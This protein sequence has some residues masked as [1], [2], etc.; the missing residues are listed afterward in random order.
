MS[1]P[2]VAVTRNPR[3]SYAARA[4]FHP[5]ELYPEY[6]ASLGHDVDTS[7]EVYPLVRE[8]LRQ[9]G[10]DAARY[11]SPDWNP[12]GEMIRPGESVVIKPNAVWDVNTKPGESVFASITHG[13][14][15]RAVLDY[16]FK[17]LD[18]RGTI[19]IADCPLVHS[20]FQNWL[21]VTGLDA[22][23]QY[24]RDR[25]S[26]AVNVYDL[27]KLYAPWD[28]TKHHAPSHL[29]EYA[30][31]D[32]LGYVEIDLGPESEF[33]ALPERICRRIYGSDYDRKQTVVHHIGG[34]HRYC[35]AATFLN[36]D[37]VVSVP[38]LKVHAKVG[39]T[40]NLKG[41]VGT[42]GDKNYIPHFRLGHPG[43]GGD[44]HP[45]L[46][47]VQNFVNRYRMWLLTGVLS[48]QTRG[49]D[50]AYRVLRP[51]LTLGQRLA[52]KYNWR[53]YGNGYGGNVI[54]GS[55]HGNDTAWRM[56]LDLTKIVLFADKSGVM[57]DTPQRRVF[58][59]VDGI[60]AGE[61]EGP[62][63]PTG[64]PCGLIV[65]GRD[66][67]AVDLV[68]A[69]LMGFDP[70]RIRMLSEGLRRPWLKSWDGGIEAV[71]VRTPD[72]ALARIMTNDDGCLDFKPPEGWARHLARQKGGD[73]ARPCP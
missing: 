22:V 65:C 18:G 60:I 45:D 15:L 14:V 57:Q 34:R 25:A 46:G 32:P 33:A 73:D 62:L 1:G 72:D 67:F 21:K 52:D 55:W 39:L 7:N 37:V 4:P 10:L 54:G 69:R 12:L 47:W 8:A 27:R 5:P 17:A 13:C 9:C 70:Q 19:T 42:Q 43:T 40:G 35:V 61:G 26:F 44:E 48:H 31:R 11:G 66:W 49:T 64:R 3:V 53:R 41:M 58:S 71:D 16:A 68:C 24:Y 23:A 2:I 28:F 38:K 59:M 50:W 63:T 6:P 29:R 51:L 30:A 36:A 20:D 56:T